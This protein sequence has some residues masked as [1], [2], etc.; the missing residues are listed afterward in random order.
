MAPSAITINQEGLS[1]MPSKVVQI[2]GMVVSVYGLDEIPPN[3][4]I[5]SVLWLLH[6]STQSQKTMGSVAIRCI[7]NWYQNRTDDQASGLIAVAFDQRNHG[8]RLVER[9]RN[10]SWN[11]GNET[12]AQDMFRSVDPSGLNGPKS[13][14]FLASSMALLSIRAC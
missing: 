11:D 9:E 4:T 6:G 3:A 7:Q 14:W 8:T 10:K 13:L 1:V 12:H 2:A 5:T